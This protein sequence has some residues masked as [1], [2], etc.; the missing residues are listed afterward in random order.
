LLNRDRD[1]RLRH[2]PGFLARVAARIWPSL[3]PALVDVMLR[4]SV[5]ESEP[6]V[7]AFSLRLTSLKDVWS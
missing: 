3:P 6:A 7:A 5:G 1:V 4:D 2:V